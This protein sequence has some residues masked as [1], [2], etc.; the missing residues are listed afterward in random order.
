MQQKLKSCGKPGNGLVAGR[1]VSMGGTPERY[2]GGQGS[3]A[4]YFL[5]ILVVINYC[6]AIV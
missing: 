6:R 3:I 5:S 2:S 1:R 4:L